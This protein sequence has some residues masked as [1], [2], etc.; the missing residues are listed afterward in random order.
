[1]PRALLALLATSTL[2]SASALAAPE[3]PTADEVKKVFDY[4]NDGKGGGPILLELTP[5][6]KVGHQEGN[7]KK[8][9]VELAEGKVPAKSTVFAFTRFF[10]P[11]D[12]EYEVTFEWVLDGD[13]KASKTAMVTTG[14]AF[15]TWKGSTLR[16]PGEYTL[17]VR[18]G[19]EVLGTAKVTIAE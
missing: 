18:N 4:F 15:G 9:C 13:V 7:P 17:R 2:L 11:A 5:C 10:V 6:L 1:M 19:E 12:D 8:A 14:Y 16:A 3:K